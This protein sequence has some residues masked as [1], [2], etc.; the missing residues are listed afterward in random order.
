MAVEWGKTYCSK[1]HRHVGG[2]MS[3]HW[4][5]CGCETAIGGGHHGV[6]CWIRDEDGQPCR[7]FTVPECVDETKR[8]RWTPGPQP[9]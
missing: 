4:T 8:K 7:D 5:P 3:L 6:Y 1:G 9:G 2:Q